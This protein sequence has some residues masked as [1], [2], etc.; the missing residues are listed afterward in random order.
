MSRSAV[1]L[2]RDGTLVRDVGYL[3]R[4]DQV[5]LLADVPAAL[6]ALQEAG[7]ALVIISNQSGIGR[8]L[9]TKRDLERVHAH[10]LQLLAEEG[11]RIDGS[12]YC[13]HAPWDRCMCRKPSPGML[14]QAAEDLDLVL[15][16]SFMVGD[17]LSDVVAGRRAQCCTVLVTDGL[18][19]RGGVVDTATD[20]TTDSLLRAANWILIRRRIP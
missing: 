4:A 20:L 10:L 12:Y 3:S 7:L 2:D 19:Y 15:T 14:Y 17:K 16:S 1:F 13:V 8:G 6:R 5:E 11:I 9:L 18:P